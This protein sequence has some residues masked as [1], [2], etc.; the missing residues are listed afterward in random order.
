MNNAL[1]HVVLELRQALFV[2]QTAAG[3]LYILDFICLI[4][5]T[6]SSIILPRL[7]LPALSALDRRSVDAC[8][9]KFLF[10]FA[11]AISGFPI[12]SSSAEQHPLNL[13]CVS[14]LSIL[15]PGQSFSQRTFSVDCDLLCS[16]WAKL[17]G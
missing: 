7:P 6:S 9:G 11:L 2:C 13:R 16:C 17:S 15:Q 14:I 5:H 4:S 10:S 1:T 8:S 3:A 12:S